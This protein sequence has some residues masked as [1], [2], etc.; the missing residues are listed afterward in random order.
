[1]PT[2]ASAGGRAPGLPR[3]SVIPGL[4][5]V[6]GEPL[7]SPF[8]YSRE[9]HDSGGASPMTWGDTDQTVPDSHTREQGWY[10]EVADRHLL[11]SGLKNRAGGTSEPCSSSQEAVRWGPGPLYPESLWEQLCDRNRDDLG[12]NPTSL[13]QHAEPD[14]EKP[15]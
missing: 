1:M 12:S 2:D 3:G 13:T 11:T 5:A 10:P 15:R 7:G 6:P 4:S 9:R 8:L 14:I